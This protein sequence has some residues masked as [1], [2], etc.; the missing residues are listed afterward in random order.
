[1]LLGIER[2]YELAVE[3]LGWESREGG[4]QG[5]HWD[6]EELLSEVI[7]L[8]LP[9]DNDGKLLNMLADCLG[10]EP[11]CERD[12]YSLRED[13]RLI[14]SWEQ[15]CKFIKHRRRYF[16]L[17]QGNVDSSEL[18]NAEEILEFIGETVRKHQL[19]TTVPVGTLVF[20][21]RQKKCGERLSLPKHFGPPPVKYAVRSNRM[22]PAGIVMFYGSNDSQT[23]VA[24]IDD[25]PALGIA[26][27]T[28][29][30]SREVEVLDL[31]RLPDRI[32]FFKQEPETQEYAYDRHG[33][34]FLH[35]FV[36][37]LAAKVAP[38][39]REHIDYVPTQVVT[40]WFRTV[41]R[42]GD[43][44][45]KGIYYPSTQRPGGRSIVLFANRYAV[46]PSARQMKKLA[47]SSSISDALLRLRYQKAWLRLV[48][49]RYIRQPQPQTP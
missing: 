29:S 2:E 37:S 33:I 45:I 27:G 25:D 14:Y 44:R 40:E 31:T 21:A 18:L 48:R 20:R 22:S 46:V 8:N 41:F 49:K 30:I 23:A 42:N 5:K 9:N 11:W 32:P 15:F 1:M 17:P 16:F 39:A 3:A 43:S 35:N 10:D 26:V 24:E 13:E 4:Y 12:P 34:S 36:E 6:S 47:Q 28:F 7:G 19:I 38:G